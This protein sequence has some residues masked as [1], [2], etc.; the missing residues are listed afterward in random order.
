LVSCG[1]PGSSSHASI[2]WAYSN[3]EGDPRFP[4]QRARVLDMR[5]LAA[6]GRGGPIV[7]NLNDNEAKSLPNLKTLVVAGILLEENASTT[8]EHWRRFLEEKRGNK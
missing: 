5:V 4:S 2:R 8:L 3:F 6:A 1:I 7:I